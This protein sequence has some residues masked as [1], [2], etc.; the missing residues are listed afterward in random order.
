METLITLGISIIF[1]ELLVMALLW[2]KKQKNVVQRTQQPQPQVN[3]SQQAPTPTP[4]VTPVS[5]V[6]PQS[7]PQPRPAQPI[8]TWRPTDEENYYDVLGIAITASEAEI[9]AAYKSLLKIWHPDIC[10]EPDAQKQM[11]YIIEA[12]EVL[13]DEATREKYNAGLELQELA[14]QGA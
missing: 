5:N 10:K 1:V 6:A 14:Y 2:T 8:R 12:Y 9:K 3:Q 7:V 4:N 13:S 11:S